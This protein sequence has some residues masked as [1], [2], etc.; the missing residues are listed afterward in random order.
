MNFEPVI[1]AH[2]DLLGEAPHW[3][4]ASGQL[5]WIDLNPGI[6]RSLDPQSGKVISWQ[7]GESI[8][9]A[10]PREAGGFIV[11][12]VSGLHAFDPATG[13]TEKFAEVEPVALGNRPNEARVDPTG[14]LW[15]ATMQNDVGLDLGEVPVIRSSGALYRV[16]ANG[17]LHRHDS[18]VGV[19]NTL[20]WDDTRGRL[21]FGDSLTGVISL[22]DWDRASG[23]IANRRVFAGP[24]PRGVPDGSA[25][26]AEG[27]V[28][29][30]RWGGGCLIRYDPDGGIDRIV[31]MP[32]NKPTSCVF[33]G[34]GLRT[35]YVTTAR[36]GEPVGGLD[37][38]LLAA[39]ST[40]PGQPC[41]RFAG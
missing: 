15:V 22:Y 31:D 7:L 8:G 16:E 12:L 33:G 9:S 6:V 39:A 40:V 37:G 18:G 36:I 19:A 28:W 11:A 29:N 13:R 38:A 4:A 26:D 5:I 21:Y 35:L 1:A 10:V 2:R 24:H 3:D 23:A 17:A 32:V 20:V 30:A 14:R 27:Y 34:P 25:L 41:T